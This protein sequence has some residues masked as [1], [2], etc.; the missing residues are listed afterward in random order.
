MTVP[1]AN[2]RRRPGLDIQRSLVLPFERGTFEGIPITSPAR[3][4]VDLAHALDDRDAIEWALRE[5]QF[6]RL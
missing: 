6:R 2:N 5:M 3:T 4:M 1:P